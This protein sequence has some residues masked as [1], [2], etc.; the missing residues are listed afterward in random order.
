[1]NIG[2]SQSDTKKIQE[3]LERFP[4][5]DKAVLYGSR[6]KG[7]FKAG[8]DIDLA[9]FGQHLSFDTLVAV[10]MAV[11]DLLLPYVVDLSAYDMIDNPALREHIDRV[12]C[13]LYQK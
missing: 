2:L 4:F 7:N 11:D 10:A 5:I 13:V 8:S 6:A 3:V 9:L 1:M 12:G